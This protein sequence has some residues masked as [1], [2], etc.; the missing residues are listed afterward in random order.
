MGDAVAGLATGTLFVA[1][2]IGWV[3]CVGSLRRLPWPAR[4]GWAYLAGLAWVCGAAFVVSRLGWAPLGR[5]LFLTLAAA[6]ALAGATLAWARGVRLTPRRSAH[7]PGRVGSIAICGVIVV[8]AILG[9]LA[10]WTRE[11]LAD[12]DGR[13]TWAPAARWICADRTVLPA[14]FANGRFS[15]SHPSYPPLLPIAD[16][17]ALSL[18]GSGEGEPFRVLYALHLAALLAVVWTAARRWG[19]RRAAWLATAAIAL[20]PFPVWNP[21]GGATGAYSDLGLASFFGAGLVLL[22][23]PRRWSDGWLAGV[24]LAAAALTKNEGSWLAV[25]GCASCAWSL[26]WHRRHARRAWL[27]AAAILAVA[28][29]SLHAWSTA[30]PW[31][32]DESYR[33]LL[34]RQN[35]GGAAAAI[36]VWM[37]EAVRQTFS[38]SKWSL[39]W[40]VFPVLL[41]IGW[42]GWARSRFAPLVLAAALPLAIGAA[43]YTLHPRAAE[44]AAVTWSRFLVQALAPAG[45]LL[46]LALRRALRREAP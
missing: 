16:C 1:A 40:W 6:A 5:G 45:A 3:A 17:A 13:M 14:V 22:A 29:L 37:A 33:V 43:A 15:V 19:G 46:A 35:I 31:R 4:A 2:G 36:A 34:E 28:M 25:V 38:F 12:W 21:D 24:L 30:I 18:A 7:G 8:A 32:G 11:P 41:A 26:P 27:T 23:R 20:A 10:H 39:F 42:R 44:L 9:V